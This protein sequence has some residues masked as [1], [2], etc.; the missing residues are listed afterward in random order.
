VTPHESVSICAND[1][2]PRVCTCV[3]VDACV[4]CAVRLSVRVNAER[5]PHDVT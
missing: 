2:K 1:L 4:Q 3:C 5:S